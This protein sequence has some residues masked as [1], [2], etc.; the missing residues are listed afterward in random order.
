MYRPYWLYEDLH[1]L[2]DYN[3]PDPNGKS[4]NKIRKPVFYNRAWLPE[5]N[6]HMEIGW[7][8][9]QS[10]A[11]KNHS[12]ALWFQYRIPLQKCIIPATHL[13]A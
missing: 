9:A 8:H 7:I 2:H 4:V 5:W 11:H 10:G 12:Y 13:L 6:E 3:H 1:Q